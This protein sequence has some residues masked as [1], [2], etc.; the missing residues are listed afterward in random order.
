MAQASSKPSS[1]F[2]STLRNAPFTVLE[3]GQLVDTALNYTSSPE[4]ALSFRP[5]TSSV[6]SHSFFTTPHL[7]RTRRRVRTISVSSRK[8]SFC[9]PGASRATMPS[10]DVVGTKKSRNF[11]GSVKRCFLPKRKEHGVS[12]SAYA[13]V[14]YRS[15]LSKI[16]IPSSFLD[17]PTPSFWPDFSELPTIPR[18]S[19][20]ASAP[21]FAQTDH[22]YAYP[23]AE[24]SSEAGWSARPSISGTRSTA[25]PQ[26]APL[27]AADGESAKF[28]SVSFRV[29]RKAASQ[30]Q[31]SLSN[32]SRPSVFHRRPSQPT[33]DSRSI[34]TSCSDVPESDLEYYASDPFAKDNVQIVNTPPATPSPSQRTRNTPRLCITLRQFAATRLP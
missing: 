26:S 3:F 16:A 19:S 12:P 32:V 7:L 9:I 30:S 11:F 31:L 25:E 14:E 18:P 5:S 20:I 13:P 2:S 29:L 34:A 24:P 23:P 21:S 28:G 4:I 15:T 33:D 22:S 10:P 17:S 1:P 6:E 8:H 27:P